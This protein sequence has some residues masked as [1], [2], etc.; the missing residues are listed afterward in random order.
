MFPAGQNAGASM[1]PLI[2]DGAHDRAGRAG[3][4]HLPHPSAPCAFASPGQ[5]CD[6]IISHPRLEARLH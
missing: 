4:G 6:K 2:T 5:E 1:T 3:A